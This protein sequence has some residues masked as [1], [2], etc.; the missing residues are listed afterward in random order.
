MILYLLGLITGIIVTLAC[1]AWNKVS[2]YCE[3]E[4]EE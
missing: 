4:D 1:L 2:N 3:G